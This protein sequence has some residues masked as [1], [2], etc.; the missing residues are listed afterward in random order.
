MAL[1]EKKLEA[2]VLIVYRSAMV[3]KLPPRSPK[4]FD[5]YVRTD[6]FSRIERY[7]LVYTRSD[8]VF[9]VYWQPSLKFEARSKHGKAIRGRVVGTGEICCAYVRHIQ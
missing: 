3:N 9:D 8:I 1:H 6:I 7:S 4:T 2:D 5:E